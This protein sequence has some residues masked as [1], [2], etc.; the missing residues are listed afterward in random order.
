MICLSFRR[1]TTTLTLDTRYD[2]RGKCSYG[3]LPF[4]PTNRFSDRYRRIS[5]FF[6]NVST[7]ENCVVER[8]KIAPPV[9][10]ARCYAVFRFYV[11]QLRDDFSRTARDTRILFPY[12][13]E[14]IIPKH[15]YQSRKHLKRSIAFD[16]ILV[17]R[18]RRRVASRKVRAKRRVK[19]QTSS[20]FFSIH[21]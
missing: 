14:R 20:D 19:P 15:R 3:G 1:L 4:P 5:F 12:L 9:H 10:A 21:A 13:L 17:E 18:V 6:Q 7:A 8:G 11:T 2:L 16:L